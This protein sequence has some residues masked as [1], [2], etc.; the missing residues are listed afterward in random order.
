MTLIIMTSCLCICYASS[1]S[2]VCNKD[3]SVCVA[4]AFQFVLIN[5]VK[6]S[7]AVLILCF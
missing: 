6:I 7:V 5:E 4:S 2:N 3:I 1:C